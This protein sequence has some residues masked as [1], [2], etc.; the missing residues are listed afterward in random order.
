MITKMRTLIFTLLICAAN[1][2]AQ[3]YIIHKV[4][5][6]VNGNPGPMQGVPGDIFAS[7]I[8]FSNTSAATISVSVK[9]Y[10]NN[11]PPYWAVCYCYIQCHSPSDNFLLVEIPPFSTQDVTLQFK[12]DSVNPGIAHDAF[13]IYE[14]GFQNNADT[15]LMTASTMPL[16]TV[17]LNKHSMTNEVVFYPNPVKN[18]AY[19]SVRNET[20]KSVTVFDA[21][22]K[23]IAAKYTIAC[24]NLSIDTVEFQNGLY[25]V[26]LVTDKNNYVKRII[27]NE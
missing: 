24:S 3:S 17:G 18:T 11:I 1:I 2:H 8:T 19:I 12:T 16:N 14:P 6:N 4:S 26:N 27:K 7:T 15:L 21:T 13:S 25:I 9:R 5:Q 22:G 23:L 10:Q 20:V